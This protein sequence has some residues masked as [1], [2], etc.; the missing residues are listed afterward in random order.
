MPH[1]SFLELIM[2]VIGFVIML[3][4]LILSLARR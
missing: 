3:A 4:I 2:L 1:L